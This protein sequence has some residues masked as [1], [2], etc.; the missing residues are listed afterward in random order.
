MAWEGVLVAQTE[1]VADRVQYI[2]TVDAKDYGNHITTLAQAGY[3]VVITVGSLQSDATST[4][5]ISYPNTL[6]IG[7]DQEQG[8]VLLN[9]AGLV[10]HETRL[11]F[12][13]AP[14]PPF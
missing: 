4:S 10:F 1:K 13:P 3:D 12:R 9:L 5:A 8:E 7:V 2:E 6:F 11:V 14:W